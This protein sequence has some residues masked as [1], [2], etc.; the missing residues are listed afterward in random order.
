MPPPTCPNL[1]L[2]VARVAIPARG[3]SGGCPCAAGRVSAP[4]QPAPPQPRD[5][6]GPLQPRHD[7]YHRRG[8]GQVVASNDTD[9]GGLSW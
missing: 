2:S 5:V 3:V 8:Q 4:L 7:G 9:D 1:F 6:H